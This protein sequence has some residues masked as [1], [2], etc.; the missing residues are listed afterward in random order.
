MV[1]SQLTSS[2]QALTPK[3]SLGQHFLINRGAVQA[4]CDAALASPASAILEIGPGRGALTDCLIA[5]GRPLWAVELDLDACRHLTQRH[6]K[7][8]NFSLENGDAIS[9]ELPKAD[10]LCIVGN[11]PYNAATAILARLLI[12]PIPWERM[13]L[14][15]QLEVGQKLVGQPGQ[16]A[17][18]PLSVLAQSV[19]RLKTLLKLGPHSFSPPPKVESIV[20]LFQPR[21]DPPAIAERRALL[22]LLHRS[23][24]H[25]RKTI[26]NNWSS[27]LSSLQIDSICESCGISP[28]SR[29]ESIAP[30]KWVEVTRVQTAIKSL[31]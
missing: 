28:I 14:M 11:L 4:I 25:R 10:S 15:F 13:V 24:A 2:S 23:F 16:R 19:A 12:E 22:A 18:G 7:A 26:A 9:V 21:P 30:D 20:L 6:G 29:A 17:Y 3:K 31:A 1:R 8:E 27:F 5:D